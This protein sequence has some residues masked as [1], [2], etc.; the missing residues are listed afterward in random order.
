KRK[1]RTANGAGEQAVSHE[2]NAVPVQHH[3]SWRVPR[4][5][6]Y[7]EIDFAKGDFV[8][9]A[10]RPGFRRWLIDAKTICCSMPGSTGIQRKVCLVQVYGNLVP[11]NQFLDCT[12]M[13]E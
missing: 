11:G 6:H 13:I 1:V 7:A 3:V 9:V 5:V 2:C 10:V 4:R 8:A 12:H